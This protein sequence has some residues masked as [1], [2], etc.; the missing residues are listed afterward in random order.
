MDPANTHGRSS[1]PASSAPVLAGVFAVLALGLGCGGVR[2][3]LTIRPDPVIASPN[4]APARAALSK[5]CILPFTP[6]PS[7]YVVSGSTE[8][9]LTPDETAALITTLLAEALSARGVAIMQL[10]ANPEAPGAEA[11]AAART[12]PLL[13]SEVAAERCTSTSVVIGR[14]HRLRERGGSAA[15]SARPASV[16]FEASLHEVPGGRR[17]WSGRFDETQQSLTASPL[18]AREYPGGGTRWLTATDFA[19]WGARKMAEALTGGS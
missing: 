15:G 11:L 18:R 7:A 17:L 1:T 14:V 5:V 3:P 6:P 13:A 19:R 8:D 9:P 2:T 16:Y 12:N 4:P 10:E